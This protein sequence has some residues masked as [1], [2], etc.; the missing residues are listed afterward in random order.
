MQIDATQTPKAFAA[1]TTYNKQDTKAWVIEDCSLKTA[2]TEGNYGSDKSADL[3][4]DL[5]FTS[6]ELS[7]DWKASKGGNSG[8]LYGVMEEPKDDAPWKTGPE[9][10]LI[11]DVGFRRSW[12]RRGRPART[13]RCSRLT[14][15]GRCS[16]RWASGTRRASSST[17]RTSST[18]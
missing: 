8:V 17:A 5:E 6:F 4:T 3:V 11:D 2:G 15:P 12:R 13:T 9:Y 10:Q 14:T 16:S 7:L 18:G 1:R